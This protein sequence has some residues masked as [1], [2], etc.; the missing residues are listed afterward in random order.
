[1]KGHLTRASTIVAAALLIGGG[2]VAPAGA[3]ANTACDTE[4]TDLVQATEAASFTRPAKDQ[5]GLRD[6]AL[7]A[8]SKFQI[9]KIDDSLQ[10]LE[11][12]RMKLESL[13]TQNKVVDASAMLM[14]HAAAVT[15]VT[16]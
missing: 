16:P 2:V 1:M 8:Q 10:K 12:Y 11:D 4:F 5:T 3:A 15:C 13:V 14:A 6:K 7:M 9:N